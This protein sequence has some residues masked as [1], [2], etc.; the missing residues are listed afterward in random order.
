[1]EKTRILVALLSLAVMAAAHMLLTRTRLGLYIRAVAQDS[2]AL[3]LVGVD[4]VKVKLWTTIISTVFATVAGVLYIIYTKSVT[5]DAEIDIAP[6]DFIVVVLGGLGNIIG[7]FLGGIILGVIYQLIFSTTGQQAL[8]LAAA[9]IILIV[10]LVVRP[11]G[12]FG[13]KT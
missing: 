2:R 9:F 3:A 12:L 4:P 6:L 8:A 10:M 7:T 13:E 1:M 5:L 11:Q